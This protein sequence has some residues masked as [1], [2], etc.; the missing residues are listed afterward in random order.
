MVVA[1]LAAAHVH[2]VAI[3]DIIRRLHCAGIK[4]RPDAVTLRDLVDQACMSSLEIV[5]DERCCLPKRTPAQVAVGDANAKHAK[6]LLNRLLVGQKHHDDG[7][8]TYVVE[9]CMF[10]AFASLSDTIVNDTY[11]NTSGT[12]AIGSGADDHNFNSTL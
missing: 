11:I 7:G 5:I 2:I 3:M 8:W 1:M 4:K 6:R 10:C 9:V 12:N